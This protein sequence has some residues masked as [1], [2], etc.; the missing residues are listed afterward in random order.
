MAEPQERPDAEKSSTP[1]GP[2]GWFAIAVLMAFLVGAI[3]YA[4]HVWRSLAGVAIPPL[5]WLFMVLGAILTVAVGG[6]LMALVFISSR[7]GRDF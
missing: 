6:G 2:A 3:A 7:E 5:G 1:M 4:V